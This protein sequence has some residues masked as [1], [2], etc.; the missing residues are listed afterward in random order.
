LDLIGV[1][2]TATDSSLIIRMEL[3]NYLTSLWTTIP[4][5]ETPSCKDILPVE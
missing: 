5:P 4:L 3:L 2:P 1:I